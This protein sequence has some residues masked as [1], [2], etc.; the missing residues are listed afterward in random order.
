MAKYAIAATGLALL[1]IAAAAPADACN[2]PKEQLIKKYG[3]VSQMPR[4]FPLPPP[5]PPAKSARAT[6]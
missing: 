3:T 2:C 4:P 6:G 5:L 1:L